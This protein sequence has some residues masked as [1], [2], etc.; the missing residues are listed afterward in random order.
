MEGGA[1]HKIS[2]DVAVFAAETSLIHL[3]HAVKEWGGRSIGLRGTDSLILLCSDEKLWEL[4]RAAEAH[5]HCKARAR[6][7]DSVL[8]GKGGGKGDGSDLIGKQGVRKE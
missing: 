2:V 3:F 6:G 8:E 1:T 5:A 4:P 7:G